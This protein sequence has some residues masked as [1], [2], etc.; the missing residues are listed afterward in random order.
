MTD[1]SRRKKKRRAAKAAPAAL[2]AHGLPAERNAAPA[3][4]FSM[5]AMLRFYSGQVP[6]KSPREKVRNVLIAVGRYA[7]DQYRCA[8]AD[9]RPEAPVGTAVDLLSG[10][11]FTE[12]VK[13]LAVLAGECRPQSALRTH[14]IPFLVENLISV[15]VFPNAMR[16]T[17]EGTPM[18]LKAV[19]EETFSDEGI[20]VRADIAL[21]GFGL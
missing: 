9:K 12:H 21:R 10:R 13:L 2:S 8:A 18:E 14:S 7:R 11:T 5:A 15:M 6:G 3:A 16:Q 17:V 20:A 1:N 19:E 4:A